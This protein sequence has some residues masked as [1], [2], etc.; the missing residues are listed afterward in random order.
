MAQSLRWRPQT[1]NHTMKKLS[2]TIFRN[3]AIGMVAQV[4]IKILSFGFSILIVRNLG[5]EAFGQYSAVIAFGFIFAFISDLGLSPYAVREIARMRDLPEGLER[6]QQ[7]FGNILR[8]RLLL[9]FLTIVLMVGTAWLTGRP[10]L[11]VGAIALNALGLILYSVQG[12]SDAVL[13][14]YE[15]L[16]ISSGSRVINQLAFVVLGGLALWLGFG[17]Y[18]L[19]IAT[20][21]GVGV[22]T[23][24]CWRGV[25]RLGVRPGA[26][27]ASMWPALLKASLPFGI[28]GFALGLSYKFDTL[29]LNIFRGDAET[30]F[31][32]AA[33]NLVFSA[34]LISNVINTALYPSLSR[35][36]VNDPHNLHKSY[37]RAIR[38][39]M[40]TALPIAF[41]IWALAGQIVPFIFTADYS[42]SIPALKIVIWVVPL[43]FASEFLGYVVLISGKEVKAARAVLVSAGVNII[44]NLLLVPRF[45][46]FAAAV[47]TVATEVVLVSQYGWVLRDLLRKMN[48]H[49]SLFRPFVAALIMGIVAYYLETRVSLLLN[50]LLSGG[51][52]VSLL[53]VFKVIGREEWRFV[54]GLRVRSEKVASS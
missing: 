35:Q 23:V 52:Y 50:I 51:L 1:L 8:L 28:I 40:L 48:W 11:M 13:A 15:R 53:F 33:Y 46:L 18:G 36:S 34:V 37:E 24:V 7:M 39:L 31:Y 30:G 14:G 44:V 12:A 45:G 20:L 47:M 22:M 3:S 42:P 16:D 21:A 5:A 10:W 26:P 41:G 17:Y 4:I 19:I 32:N 2:V 43:M 6:A 29:L 54:R 9:S 25:S 27:S 49:E 38:Y